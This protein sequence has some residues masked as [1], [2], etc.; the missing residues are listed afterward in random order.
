MTEEEKK[1]FKEKFD[2]LE[3]Y[4]DEIRRVNF[5]KLNQE[6][7]AFIDNLLQEREKEIK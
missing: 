3:A 7:I 6:Y 4:Q 2:Y 1:E 5:T